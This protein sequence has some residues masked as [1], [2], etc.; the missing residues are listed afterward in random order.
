MP[1]FLRAQRILIIFLSIFALSLVFT[2]LY[3]LWFSHFDVFSKNFC[4]NLL[5]VKSLCC[6]F[7]KFLANFCGVKSLCC[8]FCKFLANLCCV[9]SLCCKFCRFQHKWLCL[10]SLKLANSSLFLSNFMW[11]FFVDAH[12]L[13]SETCFFIPDIVFQIF[14]QFSQDQSK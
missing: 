11:K 8:K 14:P 2:S 9:K 13:L 3:L 6:K 5:V 10:Y 7:C 12:I 4:V 1:V